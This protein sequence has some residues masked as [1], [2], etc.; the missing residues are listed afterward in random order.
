MIGILIA[1]HRSSDGFVALL[2]RKGAKCCLCATPRIIGTV[3]VEVPDV[4]YWWNSQN[5]REVH[6]R[7]NIS[8]CEVHFSVVEEM[9]EAYRRGKTIPI[10]E[11]ERPG[12]TL[13]LSR[14]RY[15]CSS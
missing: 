7:R 13:H 3:E 15:V 9:I 2:K 6:S 10:A 14:T 4:F 1:Y 12:I 11:T 5:D 8:F